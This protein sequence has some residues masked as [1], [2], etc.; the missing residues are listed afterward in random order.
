MT[1]VVISLDAMGGDH[2]PRVI[3]PAALICLEK[4][5]NLHIIF[6]GKQEVLRPLLRRHKARR[7][8]SRWEIQH[9][10]EVVGMDESPAV[11]LRTKKDSAMRVAVNLVKEGRAQACVSA[12][13]TGALM[14]TAKFVLKTLPGVD[15]PAITTQF[16]AKN[17]KLV[18]VLDLGANVDSK[19]EQLYQFAVMGSM[20]SSVVKDIDSPT[21]GV[22]NVGEEEI[23]GNEQ[24]KQVNE[25]LTQ[26]PF[27]NYIGYVEGN[28]LFSGKVD[29]IVCDG[30]VG[31]IVLKAVE[32]LAKM[33]S[34]VVRATFKNS[35][36]SK[37][38]GLLALPVVGHI[39]KKFDPKRYN[40]ATLIGLN[41]IVIKS[42]GGA[43]TRSFS[44][45]IEE[46]I[47]EVERD[48]LSKIRDKIAQALQE[49]EGPCPTAES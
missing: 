49:N 8:A 45:A 43:D 17:G 5:S 3:I 9:A 21:V 31:N 12:G 39:K 26:S 46:A 42:H 48:L 16:P 28:D 22:L 10:S 38:V 47:I 36:Y 33:V 14:A 15:R 30:F 37:F 4:H 25:L 24:V 40:G 11:A 7:F 34:N 20:I 6:V 18:R 29:V 27:V 2:G 35:F 19:A 44:Y 32:G 41:G 23:K 1:K 13:N